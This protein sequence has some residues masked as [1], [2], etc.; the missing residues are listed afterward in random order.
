MGDLLQFIDKIFSVFGTAKR[1][2]GTKN[3]SVTFKGE[4]A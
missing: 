3:V 2:H 1:G 4:F